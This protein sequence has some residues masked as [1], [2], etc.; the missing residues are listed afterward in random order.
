MWKQKSDAECKKRQ[1]VEAKAVLETRTIG[2]LVAE[3]ETLKKADLDLKDRIVTW[4]PRL[5]PWRR[6]T[7]T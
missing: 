7:W 6:P 5:R 4:R 1:D 3:V 2:E